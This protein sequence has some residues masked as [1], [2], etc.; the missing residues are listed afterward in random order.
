MMCV[1]KLTASEHVCMLSKEPHK[2]LKKTHHLNKN[3]PH[4]QSSFTGG[5]GTQ[6][7]QT[8]CISMPGQFLMQLESNHLMPCAALLPAKELEYLV[9]I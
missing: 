8:R 6:G 5:N 4:V 3:N 1:T 9:T 7:F 2:Y